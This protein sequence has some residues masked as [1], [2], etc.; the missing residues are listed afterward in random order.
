[1]A[2][3]HNLFAVG[4]DTHTFG[5]YSGQAFI[6]AREYDELV[7][8]AYSGINGILIIGSYTPA[9]QEYNDFPAVPFQIASGTMHVGDTVSSHTPAGENGEPE[10]TINST[11][12][13]LEDITVPAGNFSNT[14]KIKLEIHGGGG[15]YIENIWLAQGIGIVKIERASES[16]ENY[17]GCLFTCG[18]FQ[19]D[20]VQSRV[21]NLVNY[22]IPTDT[23]SNL[24]PGI[25]LLLLK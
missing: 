8:F 15:D 10:I 18:S 6:D 1:M 4:A 22:V 13:K 16:P 12:E 3:D 23:V 11:L 2:Y 17:D 5:S 9:T 20:I 19:D 21:I 24:T 7:L 25:N 14:L